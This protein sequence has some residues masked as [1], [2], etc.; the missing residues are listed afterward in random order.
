MLYHDSDELKYRYCN[1]CWRHSLWF[2]AETIVG[3]I[4]YLVHVRGRGAIIGPE[5]LGEL[6]FLLFIMGAANRLSGV[7]LQARAQVHVGILGHR[8]S[9]IGGWG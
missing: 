5:K 6:V 3:G 8:A 4:V 2:G 9:G 7:G 1:D